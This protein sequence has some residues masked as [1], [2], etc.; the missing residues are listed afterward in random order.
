MRTPALILAL[1]ALLAC[2][3]CGDRGRQWDRPLEVLGPYKLA[4]QALWLEAN[5]GLA[6]AVEPASPEPIRRTL[7]MRRN[8]RF[9]APTP[10]GEALLVLTAGQEA[11][12]ENQTPEE[13]GL[14]VLRVGPGIAPQVTRFYS[15]AAA[16]DRLAVSADG[17][18]A[19]AHYGSSAGTGGLFRNPNEVALLDLSRP[20]GPGNPLLRTVRSLGSAPSG[21][22]FSPP[23]PVPAPSGTPRTL[24]VV[25]AQNAITFLDM[26][27]PER[28]E[29]TV[30]LTKPDSPERVQPQEV[31]FSP[32]TGT[33]FVRADGAADLYSLTLLPK[34][35][36]SSTENDYHPLINQPSSG[37][38]PLDMVLFADQGKDLIL[39]ANASQDLSLVEA[40]TS[41]FV[42]IPVNAP[43]D[44]LLAVPAE[45]PRL[46]IAYSA[47]SPSPLIHFLTL[48]GLA[49]GLEKNLTSRKLERPVH[50]LVAM[51]SGEQA[52]VVHNDKRTV[53]SVLDLKG[54][55]HT[56]SPIQGQLPLESFDFVQ[57]AQGD[58]LAG[59]AGGLNQLG[60]LDL[61]NLHPTLLR[62]DHGPRQVLAIGAAL[63]IDHQ[64]PHG[65]VTVV[66]GPGSSREATR[67]F[68]GLFLD[69]LLGRELEN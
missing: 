69:G 26:T 49:Q 65:L 25:L 3:G 67:T 7:E 35:A 1:P 34:T 24:A 23:M 60:L 51:P 54:P 15:L 31:A 53:V 50:Q 47:S 38:R 56:V 6:V 13:P 4:G 16:F 17:T 42:V 11:L 19:V 61:A 5:Q 20:A 18:M 44:T 12:Y 28:R 46:V 37:K 27:H 41:Q 21:V 30:P 66:A 33:V 64:A 2:P 36:G 40:A 58:Y 14:S 62:L 68:W 48:E 39:T 32:A 8:A 45:S 9:A 52:L 57:S 10:D 59:V 22:V 55:H 63:V 43:I 29:I